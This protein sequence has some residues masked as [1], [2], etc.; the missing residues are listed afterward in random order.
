M[1]ILML[2]LSEYIEDPSSCDEQLGHWAPCHYS[3]R[4]DGK[5]RE[6]ATCDLEGPHLQDHQVITHD[7]SFKGLAGLLAKAGKVKVGHPSRISPGT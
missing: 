5:A 7:Q 1:A 6:G 4:L 2:M 3:P